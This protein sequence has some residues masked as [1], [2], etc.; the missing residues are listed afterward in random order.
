MANILNNWR[1]HS[2][3]DNPPL[4]PSRI[5]KALYLRA[6]RRAPGTQVAFG[7]RSPTLYRSDMHDAT[8]DEV[9]HPGDAGLV[10]G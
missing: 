6:R 8:P 4:E 5:V 3:S 10:S 2:S 7:N 1:T 9:Y